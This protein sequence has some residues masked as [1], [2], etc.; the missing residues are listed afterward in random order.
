MVASRLL[1]A[2]AA[3]I[4]GCSPQ[5]EAPDADRAAFDLVIANA[6]GGGLGLAVLSGYEDA[7]YACY[8]A[9]APSSELSL[10]MLTKGIEQFYAAK[11]LMA[12]PEPERKETA[13]RFLVAAYSIIDCQDRHLGSQPP[14][15]IPSPESL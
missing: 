11:D 7:V 2:A 10:E 9:E 13:G 12:I 15:T 14:E 1:L 6:N 3:A 8:R 4:A 5:Q